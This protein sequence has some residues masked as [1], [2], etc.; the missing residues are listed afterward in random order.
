MNQNHRLQEINSS[1]V[2]N[3]EKS[4]VFVETNLNKLT[5]SQMESLAEIVGRFMGSVALETLVKNVDT[6]PKT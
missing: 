2:R 6:E 4:K 1:S 5:A 3:T